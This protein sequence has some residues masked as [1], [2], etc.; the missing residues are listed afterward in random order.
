M[1]YKC[2]LLQGHTIVGDGTTAQI[3]AIFIGE[4]EDKLPEARKG[5]GKGGEATM[6]V[7]FFTTTVPQPGCTTRAICEPIQNLKTKFYQES[8]QLPFEK[9]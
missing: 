6:C 7:Y 9:T 1:R 2:F 4:L 5:Y 8:V 3:C